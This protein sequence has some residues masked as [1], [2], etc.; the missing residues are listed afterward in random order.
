MP[1][2]IV[3]SDGGFAAGSYDAVIGGSSYTIDTGDHDL[4][5]SQADAYKADGSPKGGAFVLGKQKVS[6]KINAIQ[7]IPRPP[8]LV[9]FQFAFD[10]ERL[11]WI[12][13]NI[14][15]ASANNGAVIRTYSADIVQLVNAPSTAA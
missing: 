8:Q 13:T 9:P 14:K 10:A 4:H 3:L 2:P 11:W 5:V 6:V 12:V 7:G 15:I 1:P